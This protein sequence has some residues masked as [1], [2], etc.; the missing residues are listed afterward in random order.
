MDLEFIQA[1]ETIIHK[2]TIINLHLF[3]VVTN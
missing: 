2:Q 1:L 3:L